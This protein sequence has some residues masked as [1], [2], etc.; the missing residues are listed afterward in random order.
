MNTV[1]RIPFNKKIDLSNYNVIIFPYDEDM[2]PIDDFY[3]NN[4]IGRDKFLIQRK[5]INILDKETI[6]IKKLNMNTDIMYI[7]FSY[8]DSKEE[9]INCYKLMINNIKM[10]EYKKVLIPIINPFKFGYSLMDGIDITREILNELQEL[11][12]D[13]NIELLDITSYLTK[14]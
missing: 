1:D 11:Y 14:N 12:Y 10:N 4:N 2:N 8:Y 7:K 13:N 9:F 6:K 3:I 5:L